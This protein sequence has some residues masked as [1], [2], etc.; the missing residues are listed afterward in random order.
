LNTLDP[1]EVL[2]ERVRY[3]PSVEADGYTL[4]ARAPSA[5]SCAMPR[6]SMRPAIVD[7]PREAALSAVHFVASDPVLATALGG[8]LAPA[9]RMLFSC[10]SAHFTYAA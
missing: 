2:F 8:L 3:E 10:E 6:C 5:S 7:E 9:C 4:A 1:L